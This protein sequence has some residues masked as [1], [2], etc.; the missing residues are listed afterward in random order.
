MPFHNLVF[1]I[2]DNISY[3]Q[4]RLLFCRNDQPE[5]PAPEAPLRHELHI[6]THLPY[7]GIPFCAY[8]WEALHLSG[9]PGV[10]PLGSFALQ[11]DH[12]P[13]SLTLWT[14]VLSLLFVSCSQTVINKNNYQT[15]FSHYLCLLCLH[16]FFSSNRVGADLYQFELD[17]QH[18][19]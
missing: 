11:D 12:P 16:K 8:Q 10:G 14:P 1:I 15:F 7:L 9:S 13:G 19:I 17:E 4:I 5:A 6:L 18:C 3:K 2:N